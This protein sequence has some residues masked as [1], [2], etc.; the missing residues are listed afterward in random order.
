MIYLDNSATTFP[1]PEE[2]YKALDFANRNLAFNAGRG[3]YKKA[4]EVTKI[5]DETREEIASLVNANANNVAFLSSATECLNIIIYGLQLDDGDVVYISP[6]EH[7]AIVRPLFGIQKDKKIEIILIPFD[8]Q[9]WHPDLKKLD[10]MMAIKKPKAVF[11]SQI[12]NVTG[13]MLDYENIFEITKKYQGITVLDSAQAFGVVNPNLKNVDFCIFAGHKSLYASFG[14]AGIVA[15]DF[16]LL[17]VTKSGGTGSD[18]L[19]HYMPEKGYGRIEAG[20]PNIVAIFGLHESIKWLKNNDVFKHENSLTSCLINKLKDIENIVVYAPENTMDLL[21]I[22][23]INVE[24]Y[25]PADIGSILSNEFDIAVRTGYHC[26]PFVHEFIGSNKFNGTVRISL[27]AF[28]TEDD[29]DKL[30]KALNTL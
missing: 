2:V 1:K 30:I 11:V 23:S 18:S 16:G 3:N 20:S 21:G 27:G 8:K 17:N 9:T 4:Q 29:V 24:G 10:E 13:L 26:S 5:I 14:I 15:K 6:F 12:S 22:I 25:N 7:N 28:N 19:N